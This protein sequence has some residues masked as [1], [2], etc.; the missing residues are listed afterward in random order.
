[1]PAELA[2]RPIGAFA[3]SP[4][5]RTLLV[6]E[7]DEEADEPDDDDEE[8]EESEL[9]E[10]EAVLTQFLAFDLVSGER[11][12]VAGHDSTFE[13]SCAVSFDG[14]V[15]VIADNYEE[16]S[17]WAAD[18]GDLAVLEQ[19]HPTP[20]AVMALS[21]G[22][23]FAVSAIDTNV[24]VWD[25]QAPATR[26]WP[27]GRNTWALSP[28]AENTRLLCAVRDEG[29]EI[30]DVETCSPVDALPPSKAP[31]EECA[32]SEDGRL[33][34]TREWSFLAE[35]PEV[36]IWRLPERRLDHAVPSAKGPIAMSRDGRLLLAN[37]EDGRIAVWNVA[38][39]RYEPDLLATAQSASACA[40]APDASVAAV[41]YETGE[42]ELWPAL[43][44][45]RACD[46]AHA[47]RVLHVSFRSDGRTLISSSADGTVR[48][49]DTT[50][51][52]SHVLS[53][54]EGRWVR[55]CALSPNGRHA[56][57]VDS[58]ACLKVW[59]L[60][61]EA[62]F[63]TQYVHG[64]LFDCQW[65]GDECLALAGTRGVY[66]FQAVLDR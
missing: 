21:I 66:L 25:V 3:L 64:V 6:A 36:K 39:G 42:L 16:L 15:A 20:V 52:Q 8:A 2:G 40:L 60:E 23:E 29:A 28:F 18:T 5:G 61:N 45:R 11:V 54:T 4:D 32:V 55:G 56:A 37:T 65:L 49:W 10:D 33:V 31:L 27:E 9:D 48:V 44:E 19:S 1:M 58:E 41:G 59:D 34:A 13:G 7:S 63:I 38:E 50:G 43:A 17:I 35:D 26:A 46:A 24:S 22:A 30:W 57:S 51:H 12:V 53:H 14:R 47:E 62:C